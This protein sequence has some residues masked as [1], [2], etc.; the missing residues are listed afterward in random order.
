MP[1]TKDQKKEILDAL[2]NEMKSA[3]SVVFADYKGLPVKEV[4]KLRSNLREKG[5]S[6][7]VAK[8]T[9]IKLA[10]KEVGYDEIPADVL[11]GPVAIVCSMED[12][13]SGA[14]LVFEFSKKNT[15][16]KLRGSLLDGKVLSVEETK[17]LASLPGKEE[18]LAKLVY[19]F[20]AP[21][22]GFHGVL[23][24]TMSGFVRVL[25]SIAKKQ[26]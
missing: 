18:L 8:K 16:L 6:Y 2:V 14:K 19:L 10:A 25:D 20:K 1:L 12:E 9:L 21:I 3:K 4:R 11:E 17:Q 5:V 15:S 24:G 22:Q 23:H 26:A 13:V 7:Q